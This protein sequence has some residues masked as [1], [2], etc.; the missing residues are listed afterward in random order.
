MTI[1]E[2]HR[3]LLRQDIVAH[4]RLIAQRRQEIRLAEQEIALHEVLIELA[5][6]DQLLA[7]VGELYED[8]GLT[9]TFAND[10]LRHCQEQDIP[11]PK[12][13]TL[14]PVDTEGPSPRLTARVTRG[15]WDVEV[16]WDREVG[17]LVRPAPPP[18][19][20]FSDLAVGKL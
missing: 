1:L 9:S 2:E 15:V 12:G 8:S 19:P 13:V 11:L 6:N 5:R 3:V 10:P 20:P 4:E 16:V 7:A 14:S 18:K 17:F